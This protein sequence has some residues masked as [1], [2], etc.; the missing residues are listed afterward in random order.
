MSDENEYKTA[1][2]MGVELHFEDRPDLADALRSTW[3]IF[4]TLYAGADATAPE[5]VAKIER[6]VLDG[7]LKLHG[8]IEPRGTTLTF[9]L[10]AFPVFKTGH[11]PVELGRMVGQLVEDRPKSADVLPFPKPH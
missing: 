10:M 3:R 6:L 2:D 4:Q 1:L 8:L 5:T 11:G 7:G 9:R